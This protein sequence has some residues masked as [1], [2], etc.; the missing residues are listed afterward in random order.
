MVGRDA[1]WGVQ[2]DTVLGR[3]T[4][5]RKERRIVV[6]LTRNAAAVGRNE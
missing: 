1:D 4:A 3:H 6:G 5:L 2:L